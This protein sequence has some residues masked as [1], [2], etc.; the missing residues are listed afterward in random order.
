[1]IAQI[2]IASERKNYVGRKEFRLVFRVLGDYVIQS[3]AT[4]ADE[5]SWVDR[6]HIGEAQLEDLRETHQLFKQGRD[7]SAALYD[8]VA[9]HRLVVF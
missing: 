5:N 9:K 1:M 8:F 3:S 2:T 7:Q 6:M 4:P